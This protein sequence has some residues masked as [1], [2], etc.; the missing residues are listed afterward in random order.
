MENLYLLVSDMLVNFGDILPE[1][2][3]SSTCWDMGGNSHLTWLTIDSLYALVYRTGTRVYPA[4][5][6]DRPVWTHL[7][8]LLFG[9]E[10]DIKCSTSITQKKKSLLG[11]R[12]QSI[13]NLHGRLFV[14]N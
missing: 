13:E 9:D 4:V 12:H 3:K 10:L 14:V 6:P 7:P 1:T 8:C 2:S 5:P 11:P